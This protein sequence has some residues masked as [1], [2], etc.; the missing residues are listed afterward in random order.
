MFHIIVV[1]S[2]SSVAQAVALRAYGWFVA[3]FFVHQV[4]QGVRG[5]G[6]AIVL[7]VYFQGFSF[8]RDLFEVFDQLDAFV[9]DEHGDETL[10]VAQLTVYFADPLDDMGV[11]RF[12]AEESRAEA[13]GLQ[14]LFDY[15][16]V[17]EA[18]GFPGETGGIAVDDDFAGMIPVTL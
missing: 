18:A 1:S 12:G 17:G 13:F 7:F 4:A 6:A 2:Q 15:F 10:G 8:I 9:V 16:V 11:L 14:G 3:E 5:V